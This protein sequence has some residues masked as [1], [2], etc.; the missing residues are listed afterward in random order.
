MNHASLKSLSPPLSS[1]PIYF[2]QFLKFVQTKRVPGS[3]RYDGCVDCVPGNYFETWTE[4]AP[5]TGKNFKRCR[6]LYLPEA[7]LDFRIWAT[8]SPAAAL[9][10]QPS[11]RYDGCVD[12]APSNYSET[13]TE[14]APHIGSN[15]ERFED[16]Y[17]P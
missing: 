13:W 4:W 8:F 3:S 2:F 17:L 14:W 5:R 1:A 11:T 6:D 10:P 7:G 15:L 16:F 9:N 12:C